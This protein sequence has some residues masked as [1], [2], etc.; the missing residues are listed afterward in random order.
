[1]SIQ[2]TAGHA[3]EL[4]LKK[5]GIDCSVEIRRK[6]V[7][8]IEL[9]VKW[10]RVYNLTAIRDV[11]KMVSHHVLDSLAVVP[12]L[13]GV[14]VL[15][16]GSGA[17]LPG[18]PLALISPERQFVLLDSNAK[19]TRFMQQAKTELGLDNVTVATARVEDFHPGKKFD[20]I[21]SRAFASISQMLL[22]AGHLCQPKG[23]IVALKGAYPVDELNDLPQGYII[24]A[25]EHITVANMDEQRHVV[26]LVAL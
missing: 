1:M 21:L 25:V 26:E 17:G 12:F 15:D 18:V 14:E 16:V 9:L 20:T 23:V 7:T 5:Q 11:K 4:G 10:N 13:H 24:K 22:L 8:F 6:L 19:K 2:K 3:L